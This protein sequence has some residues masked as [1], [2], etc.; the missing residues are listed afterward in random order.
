MKPTIKQQLEAA[1]RR[2]RELEEELAAERRVAQDEAR[3]R[4]W[5]RVA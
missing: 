1:L 2:I 5:G 4:S 3:R